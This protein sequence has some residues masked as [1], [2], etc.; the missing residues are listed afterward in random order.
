MSVLEEVAAPGS[1]W[2]RPCN[3]WFVCSGVGA[4]GRSSSEGR[5]ESCGEACSHAWKSGCA[6]V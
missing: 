3:Q 1:G 4:L 6:S 2:S 5:G